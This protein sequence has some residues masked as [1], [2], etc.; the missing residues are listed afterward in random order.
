[1]ELPHFET[2]RDWAAA[3]ERLGFDLP[4]PRETLGHSLARLALFVRD[5]RLRE[6]APENQALEAHYGAFVFSQARP[7]REEAL[8]RVRDVSYG[9]DP[10]DG[11]IAGCE[12]RLYDR[13]PVPGPDDPDPRMPAVVVWAWRD[14]FHLV[15]SDR[16]ELEEL[17]RIARSIE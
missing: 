1:M 15:A 16:L 2:L 13:G 11:E 4:M 9:D 3:S 14:R 8:R 7:G 12:A 10:Q 6:V 5:H 17:V